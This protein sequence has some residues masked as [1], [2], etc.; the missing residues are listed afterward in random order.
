MTNP[1]DPA[2]LAEPGLVVLDVTAPDEGTLRAA[3]TVLTA[4]W[5]ASGEGCVRRVPGEPGVQLRLVA[6][7][8]RSGAAPALEAPHAPRYGP[9]PPIG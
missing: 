8:R 4:V 7:I 6:D 9:A 5:A 2:H 3:A 1:I